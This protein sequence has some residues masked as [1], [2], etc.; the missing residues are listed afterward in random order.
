MCNVTTNF[1]LLEKVITDRLKKGSKANCF[2]KAGAM[3]RN[4][5]LFLTMNMFAT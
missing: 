5:S 3:K 1:T 4:I 2:F